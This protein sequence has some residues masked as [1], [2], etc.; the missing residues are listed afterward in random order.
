MKF[1]K[2]TITN[3]HLSFNKKG[4]QVELFKQKKQGSSL[5]WI[6]DETYEIIWYSSDHHEEKI[7]NFLEKLHYHFDETLENIYNY[8][9]GVFE[10]FIHH[11]KNHKLLI[12][13]DLYGVNG[14]FS[15]NYKRQLIFF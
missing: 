6:E 10:L 9:G 14:S 5:F 4:F 3:F 1:E 8:I 15:L 13:N 12:L 2:H 11:K 7:R